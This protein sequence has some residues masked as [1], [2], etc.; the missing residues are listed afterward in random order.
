M[1]IKLN[2]IL[3]LGAVYFYIVSILHFSGVK[4][5]MFYI[6]YDVKSTIY[7][8]RIISILSFVFATFLFAGYKI[9]DIAIVKYILFAGFFGISGLAVNNFLTRLTFRNNIIYWI[10]I[11]LLGLYNLVLY[12]FYKKQLNE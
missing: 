4:V 1:K 5:P 2:T 6:Y 8:D 12:F 3:L 7:Q 11:G 10:E 9:K